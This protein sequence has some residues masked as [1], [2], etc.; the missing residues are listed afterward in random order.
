MLWIVGLGCLL[1]GA[2]SGALL[3]KFLKSDEARVQ[4][5]ESQLQQLSD[6]YETYKKEVHGHFSDS[7]I[8]IGKLTESYR[9]VY[10]HMAHGARNLCPD[11]IATQLTQAAPASALDDL[12]SSNATARDTTLLSPPLDYASPRSE[13]PSTTSNVLG[14]A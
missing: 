10:Q 1:V 3:F 2:I 11:Y 9:E 7:A 4:Q 12:E 5:L 8:L 14:R 13:E 6:E